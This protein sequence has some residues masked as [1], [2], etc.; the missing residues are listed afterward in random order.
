MIG[1]PYGTYE[2]VCIFIYSKYMVN[3]KLVDLTSLKSKGVDLTGLKSKR[4]DL[5]P[6]RKWLS[7]LCKFVL[8]IHS[9]NTSSSESYS[10]VSFCGGAIVGIRRGY[11]SSTLRPSTH[12]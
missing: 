11:A 1:D 9:K 12:L 3:F 6:L 10:V 2:C 4:A 8:F 5:T 7:R